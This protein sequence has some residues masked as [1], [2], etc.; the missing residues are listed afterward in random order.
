MKESYK[1]KIP[2]ILFLLALLVI[3]ILLLIEAMSEED[4][5]IQ[6]G[7]ITVKGVD[8]VVVFEDSMSYKLIV[9][10][11]NKTYIKDLPKYVDKY[12]NL[13]PVLCGTDMVYFGEELCPGCDCETI[14]EEMGFDLDEEDEYYDEEWY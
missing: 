8:R 12:E 10:I 7:N 11:D 2:T 9:Q 4:Y 1:W 5:K 13:Y 14:C 6:Y 3:S